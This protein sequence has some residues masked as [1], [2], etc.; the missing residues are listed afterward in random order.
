MFRECHRGRGVRWRRCSGECAVRADRPLPAESH[1]ASRLASSCVHPCLASQ[2]C[3]QIGTLLPVCIS[4]GA[5]TDDDPWAWVGGRT[6]PTVGYSRRRDCHSV[7]RL[8]PPSTFSRCFNVDGEGCQQ[9]DRTL[10]AGH[11]A[12]GWREWFG[13]LGPRERVQAT[14]LSSATATPAVNQLVS[15]GP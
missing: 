12:G 14:R 4:H 7:A 9:C 10:A 15:Q 1:P 6:A 5:E 13:G 3:E 2:I 11:Q 8:A